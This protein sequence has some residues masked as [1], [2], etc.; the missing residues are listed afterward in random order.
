MLKKMSSG[1]DKNTNSIF[2]NFTKCNNFSF[3]MHHNFYKLLY[4]GFI[5]QTVVPERTV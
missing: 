5:N 2:S 4:E 3:P 1:R